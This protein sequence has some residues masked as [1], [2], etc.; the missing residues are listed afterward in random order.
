MENGLDRKFVFSVSELMVLLAIAGCNNLVG[1]YDPTAA[2]MDVNQVV[3]IIFRLHHKGIVSEE[4]GKIEV[5]EEYRRVVDGLMNA[6]KM[7]VF[8]VDDESYP[9][10]SLYIGEACIE[11]YNLDESGKKIVLSEVNPYRVL[12]DI[13]EKGFRIDSHAEDVLEEEIKEVQ[14]FSSEKWNL[15]YSDD[16]EELL[17]Q[18]G[19][20]GV[21]SLWNVKRT[22]EYAKLVILT[23]E[24]ED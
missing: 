10:Y 4:N 3:Q 13:G 19:I 5:R 8:S 14:G 20:F 18:K 16:K 15:E 11:A 24:L 22:Q 2:K 6:K 9:E 21:G 7:F 1:L 17:Q 12:C 23:D